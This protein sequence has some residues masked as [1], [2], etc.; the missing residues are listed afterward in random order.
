MQVNEYKQNI[1]QTLEQDNQ[2]QE[3]PHYNQLV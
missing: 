1:M 3:I 2:D